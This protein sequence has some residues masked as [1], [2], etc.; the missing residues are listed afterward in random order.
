[1]PSLRV[2]ATLSL[3][4]CVALAGC[5]KEAPP[6][7][8]APKVTVAKPIK[9]QLGD[10][11][12][13]VGQFEAVKEVMI[14]SRVN[15]YLA[16][17]GFTDGEVVKA[18]ALLFRIDPR[19]FE[20]ALDQARSHVHTVEAKLDNARK[21]R[22]RARKLLPAQAVSQEEFEGLD[23]TATGAESELAEARAAQHAAELNLEFTRI[24][25]PIAGRVSYKRIDVGNTVKADD[26]LLT[27]VVSVDPIR[28]TFQASEA[29]YLRYKRQNANGV[30]GAP[31]RIRLQDENAHARDGKLEFFDNEITTGTGTIRG[32]ALVKN[33]DGFLVPGM[34]GHL[35][36]QGTA[37]YDGLQLP[38]T[39]IATRGPQRIVYVVGSDNVVTAKPIEIGPLN[40]GLRVIRSGL[41]GDELVVVTGLQRVAPGATVQATTTTIEVPAQP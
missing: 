11:D 1:M 32:R 30:I 17:I 36:V 9:R 7:A 10:W 33:A 16:E 26:T 4:I 24:T 22:E 19:P 15:G 40:G 25:A 31:V 2:A 6:P 3:F 38:D 20:A 34:F 39:A 29:L 27:T 41:T 5:S 18:G 8:A 21:A 35:Q 13:Y 12:D 23:S 14:R 37:A 28:F